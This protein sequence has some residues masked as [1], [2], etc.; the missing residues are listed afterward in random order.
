MAQ[1]QAYILPTTL[2]KRE[3]LYGNGTDEENLL[4][5]GERYR[6]AGMLDEAALFYHRA[7]AD[8]ELE[9]VAGD[10]VAAGDYFTFKQAMALLGRDPSVEEL[11]CLARSAESGGKN[12]FAR[13]ARAA[14]G[15]EG[16]NED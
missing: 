9:K 6:E 11:L 10:A 4:K 3:L 15:E 7:E 16:G 8:D 13:L 14:A 5:I 2:E 12:N 1:K